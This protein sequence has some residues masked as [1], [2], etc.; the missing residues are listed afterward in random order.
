MSYPR[1]CRNGHVI[2]GPEDEHLGQHRQCRR[3]RHESQR[4]AASR[5]R[6]LNPYQ[7]LIQSIVQ[8]A[9]RR[10]ARRDEALR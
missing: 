6:M 7:V 8:G 1:T 3:C 9:K 2:E 4:K 5:W 10:L